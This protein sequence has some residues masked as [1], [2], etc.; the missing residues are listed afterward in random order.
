MKME[1][2]AATDP[3]RDEHPFTLCKEI[4]DASALSGQLPVRQRPF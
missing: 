1:K 3:F 2:R 4:S